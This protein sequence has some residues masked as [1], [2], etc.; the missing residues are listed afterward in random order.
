M[1]VLKNVI[2]TNGV[3]YLTPKKQTFSKAYIEIRDKEQ[4]FLEDNE[5][6]KLPFTSKNNLHYHEWLLR[7]QSTKRFINY[8]KTKKEKLT[9][10]DLG[11]GNGWFTNLMAEVSTQNKIIGLDINIE[12][13]EQAARIFRKTNLNFSYG[14]VFQLDKIIEKQF[15]LIV[16]NASVQY[17]QNFDGLIEKLNSLLKFKGELH[18]IDSPFYK[19]NELEKAR[20]RSIDYY[21]NLGYPEMAKNYFHHQIKDIENFDI[22][23]K[24]SKSIYQ[25]IIRKQVNPFYW[26][27]LFNV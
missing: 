13:L 5:V 12:E 24:P 16:L 6:K 11:C 3:Y 26:V 19:E 9:I 2:C 4:R 15:D 18:I 20:Q 27:R 8:L 17:F 14:D 10:L 7:Q 21:T 25:K 22:L 1:L 23:Y